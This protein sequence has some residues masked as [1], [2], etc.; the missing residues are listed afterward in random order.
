MAPVSTPQF[1]ALTSF[2]FNIGL[3][4]FRHSTVVKEIAAGAYLQAAAASGAV[5]A[6]RFR[7]R[8]AGGRCARAPPCS[9]EG[10]LPDAAGGFRPRA[11]PDPAPHL[12]PLGHR[13]RHGLERAGGEDRGLLRRAGRRN[14]HRHPRRPPGPHGGRACTLGRHRRR[15]CGD[16]APEPHPAGRGTGRRAAGPRAADAEAHRRSRARRRT[17][18]AGGYGPRLPAAAGHRHARARARARLHAAA[19]RFGGQ[20]RPRPLRPDALRPGDGGAARALL[21]L[22]AAVAADGRGAGL[23]LRKLRPPGPGRGARPRQPKRRACS[24]PRPWSK[25][26]PRPCSTP[27]PRRRSR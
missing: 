5:A 4:N 25:P 20:R 9:G 13:R 1:E 2:A 16:R 15:R 26:I 8:Y 21:R 11:Q 17:R 14:R 23:R 3:D 7:R 19:H 22:R 24:T 6:R 10:A 12:R 27:R 18:G